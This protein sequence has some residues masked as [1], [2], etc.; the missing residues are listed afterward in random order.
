MDLTI[1]KNGKDI[2]GTQPV[3]QME[4]PLHELLISLATPAKS[5]PAIQKI[6]DYYSDAVLR[7]ADLRRFKDELSLLIPRADK[8]FQQELDVLRLFIEQAIKT[9]NSIFAYCD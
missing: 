2:D 9:E 3:F 1:A 4:E 8:R 6:E 5:F 7:P